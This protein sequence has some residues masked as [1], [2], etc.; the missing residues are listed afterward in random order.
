M[1]VFSSLPE[2]SCQGNVRTSRLVRQRS[3]ANLVVR[4]IAAHCQWVLA[5]LLPE[6]QLTRGPSWCWSLPLR[7]RHSLRIRAGH[8]ATSRAC[9]SLALR[10]GKTECREEREINSCGRRVARN[11]RRAQHRGPKV[12][13][14]RGS[15]GVGLSR[16]RCE[17]APPVLCVASPPCLHP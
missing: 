13:G 14:K 9:S 3:L 4:L 5:R 1:I 10:G 2:T 8:R 17:E 6:S 7:E 16:H 11:N 12:Q 15:G